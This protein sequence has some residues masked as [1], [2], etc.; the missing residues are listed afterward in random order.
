MTEWRMVPVEPTEAMVDDPTVEVFHSNRLHALQVWHAMLAAA[1]PPPSPWRDIASAPR[2]GTLII[3]RGT[4]AAEHYG[5]DSEMALALIRWSDG[6]TDWPGYD[7]IAEP[8]AGLM[9]WMKPTAWMPLPAP[10]TDGGGD[11]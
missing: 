2:D 10:P 1:P 5:P 8:G 9:V 4:T 3:G 6:F 7:W 11:E